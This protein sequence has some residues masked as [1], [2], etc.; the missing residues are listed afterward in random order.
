VHHHI[1]QLKNS[2]SGQFLPQGPQRD[3]TKLTRRIRIWKKRL[4]L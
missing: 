2:W 3:I 4:G 1:S